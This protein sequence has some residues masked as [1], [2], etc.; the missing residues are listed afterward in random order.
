MVNVTHTEELRKAI[1]L[2]IVALLVRTAGGWLLGEGA[3]FGPDGTGAEA[4]VYLGGHPYPLHIAMLRMFGGDAQNLSVL[5]GSFNCVLL[6]FWGRRVGLGGAGGWLAAAFPL[7]VLPGTLAAGD[8]PALSVVLL[9]AVLATYPGIFRVLGGALAGICVMVK[10]I[11]LPALVLLIARPMSLLGAAGSLM[12]FNQ[13]IR[14][15]WA[16]M[17]DGGIL[18]TWWVSS[19]GQPPDN[20]LVW[21]V[22]GVSHLVHAE[23]W[24]LLWVLPFA[25]LCFFRVSDHRIRVASIGPL[26]A[27][28]VVAALFGDRLELRYLSSAVVVAL[29]FLGAVFTRSLVLWGTTVALIWPTAALMTQIAH[30][31]MAMDPDALIPDVP[32][33]SHPSVDAR[34]IFD[35]CS[36]EGATR[37]R[38]M[39]FQL[40]ETAPQGVTIVTDARPDGREGELFWPLMVLRPDLKVQVR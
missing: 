35:A 34:I 10:P 24:A 7:S 27:A 40:A 25:M 16:P 1:S 2:M 39:A 28:T 13:F 8:A 26:F 38:Q 23:L 37:L 33:V 9:G 31:R 30:M 4:A 15:I 14:P 5:A 17:P 20:L 11:A 6:W 12:T 19:Q 18:G 29:P 22:D 36:T 3:V 32:M 21:F